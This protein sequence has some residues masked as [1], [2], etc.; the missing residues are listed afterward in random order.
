MAFLLAFGFS[1]ILIPAARRIGLSVGLVDQ[2]GSLKIH[3]E[4]IS[5]LGG[6]AVVASTLGAFSITHRGLP[7]GFASG[8]ALAL[9]VGILDD[10]RQ[11]PPWMRVAVLSAA[12]LAVGVDLTGSLGAGS[13]G[14][15]A[16]VLACSNSVNLVDGQDGLASGLAAI[17]ALCLAALLSRSGDVG[18]GLGLALGGSLLAFLLWNRPPAR[19]FLGNGG[20]YGVGVCLAGLAA[21]T[22]LQRGWRGLFAAGVCLSV[23]ALELLFT[24]ARRL[25][26]RRPLTGGDRGHAYD[27]A[28]ERLGSRGKS[29]ILFWGLGGL[30][31][32]LGL[33]LATLPIAA[34]IAIVSV[35]AGVFAVLA[36]LIWKR[37]VDRG[38]E[39]A[40]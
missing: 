10:A 20:A 2:P 30:A 37:A 16:L 29:T 8:L 26:S 13:L 7:A 17:S 4:P 33:A 38:V 34:G 21:E 19:I 14:I 18:G 3:D 32:A 1:L 36:F 35:A 24:V 9:L 22:V 39:T 27:L 31:G 28:A 6:V 23:F 12:G 25:R 11:L 40:T 5:V 15:V